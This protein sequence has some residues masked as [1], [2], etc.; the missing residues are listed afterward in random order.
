MA[1]LELDRL[2]KRV[3]K[4]SGEKGELQA[5]LV[6]IEQEIREISARIEELQKQ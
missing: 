1:R 6:E 5:K 4:L 3:E 2:L